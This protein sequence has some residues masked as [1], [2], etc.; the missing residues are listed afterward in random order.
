MMKNLILVVAASMLVAASVASQEKK[1]ADSGVQ[2][3][4]ELQITQCALKVSGMSSGH[5]AS[6]VRKMLLKIDG[7]RDAEADWKTGDVKVSYDARKTA[8]EK[9]VSTFNDHGHGYRA[10]LAESKDNNERPAVK[11]QE[12]NKPCCA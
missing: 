3:T 9:I 5:C 10:K 12:G 8:P 11:G 4:A 2:A 6:A 1:Q 7:V